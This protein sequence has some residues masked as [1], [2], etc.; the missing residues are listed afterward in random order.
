MRRRLP[1]RDSKGPFTVEMHDDRERHE[2]YKRSKL[3]LTALG[4]A[5]LAGRD[6]FSRHNPV[7]RWWGGTELTNDRLWR[8]DAAKQVLVAP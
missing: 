3:S 5:I 1:W 8:W 2:R 7:H 4:R 6:D